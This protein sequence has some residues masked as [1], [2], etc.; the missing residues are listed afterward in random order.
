MSPT[1]MDLVPSYSWFVAIECPHCGQSNRLP[2]PVSF[3][4]VM[5]S[6][7]VAFGTAVPLFSRSHLPAWLVVALDVGA[8]LLLL[9][10]LL[11]LYLRLSSRP[12]ISGGYGP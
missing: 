9:R 3:S 11:L 8:W 2:W 4:L 12:F 6:L 1:F 5:L 10:V 7:L